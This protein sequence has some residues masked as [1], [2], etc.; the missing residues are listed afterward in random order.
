MYRLADWV[1]RRASLVRAY[2]WNK[3]VAENDTDE[4]IRKLG[5]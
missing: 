5:G 4:A 1:L 3:V 2:Y